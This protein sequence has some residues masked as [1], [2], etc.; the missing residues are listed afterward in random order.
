MALKNKTEQ[1]ADILTNKIRDG[2]FPAGAK[3]P[4]EREI[5]EEVSV[6]RV[7]VKRAL[8]ILK[9]K[10]LIVSKSRS[11]SFVTEGAREIISNSEKAPAG[12]ITKVGFAMHHRWVRDTFFQNI[13]KEFETALPGNFEILVYFQNY[14][15]KEAYLQDGIEIM[16][17]DHGFSDLEINTLNNSG[18]FCVTLLSKREY[19]NYI[20]FDNCMAGYLTGKL[21]AEYGHRNIAFIDFAG[22][23]GEGA[24]R[25]NGVQKAVGEFGLEMHNI[26]IASHPGDGGF[27]DIRTALDYLFSADW[28][29][30]AIIAT[31]DQ[32]AYLIRDILQG[33]NISVPDDIS[34]VGFNNNYYSSMQPVPL[35]T[36]A[37][38]VGKIVDMLAEAVRRYSE[39]GIPEFHETITPALIVRDSVKNLLK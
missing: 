15:M 9:K 2:I 7:I 29:F 11:G 13:I 6:S 10:K 21:L 17:V 31:D 16:F 35:T 3:L 19:G 38:P 1:V 22:H 37:F 36:T 26:D 14:I 23:R 18:I 20:F 24:E 33:K 27:A 34:L 30:T 28:K 4:S 12:K 39:A 5:E 32:R 25:L 8:N